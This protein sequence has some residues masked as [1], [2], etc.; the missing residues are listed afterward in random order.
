MLTQLIYLYS[1]I[2]CD[3]YHGRYLMIS[4]DYLYKVDSSVRFPVDIVMCIVMFIV[5]QIACVDSF[6]K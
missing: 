2:I 5:F 1:V 6:I 3:C 4:K